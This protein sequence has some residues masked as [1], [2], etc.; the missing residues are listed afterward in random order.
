LVI[1]YPP[2]GGTD[3]I[4]RIIAQKL[5]D[6]FGQQVVTDNRSGGGTIV[7]SEIV[8]HAPPDGYTLLM[9]TVAL[10][11]NESL[12]PKLPYDAQRDL[13]PIA[14]VATLPHALVVNPA[15][16]ARSV[17]EL[18]DLARARPGKLS[19]G[20]SGTGGLSHLVG[21]LFR[22]QAGID[23]IHIPY[24]GGG[25]LMLDLLGGQIQMS[26]ASMPTV[27]PQLQAG[28]L[29]GLGVTTSMR[30]SELPDIPTIA[31]AGF[32]GFEAS[33]WQMLY[34]P[35]RTPAGIIDRINGELRAVLT[36][37]EV[38]KQ[39]AQNGFEPIGSTPAEARNHFRSEVTK[40]AKVVK[41]SGA[42]P[43]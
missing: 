29:R 7:G 10:A 1:P 6:R 2:G 22:V 39:L 43:D 26:F 9:N 38:R 5:G 8:A 34:A 3:I 23:I 4:G 35:A 12:H 31:E 40:W 42:R 25:P 18:V 30:M 11:I 14:L 17:R 16:P 27:L 28:K 15:V 21:E 13:A 36:Q 32:P 41:I 37:P 20:S 24:R 19:Y 33:N